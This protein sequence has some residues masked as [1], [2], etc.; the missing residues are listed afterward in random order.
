VGEAGEAGEAT[1][2]EGVACRSA[3]LPVFAPFRG[4]DE[5]VGLLGNAF[6]GR[7]EQ[8]EID[9]A[10][11]TVRFVPRRAEATGR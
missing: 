3:E 5:G 10:E 7:F 9:F 1:V 4:G 11:G 2:F 8:V 6:L